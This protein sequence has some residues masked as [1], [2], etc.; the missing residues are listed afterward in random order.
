MIR[1]DLD[2]LHDA[3]GNTRSDNRPC[4]DSLQEYNAHDRAEN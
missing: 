3:I 4:S 1:D 2:Q